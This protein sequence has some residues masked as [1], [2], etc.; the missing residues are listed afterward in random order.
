M[1]AFAGVFAWR[2]RVARE[3]D[4]STRYVL[5]NHMLFRISETLPTDVN[6]LLACCNPVP[7][8][9][10]LQAH[11]LLSIIEDAR[12]DSGL[13]PQPFIFTRYSESTSVAVRDS[14]GK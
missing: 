2:D 9:V 13:S 5:P 1:K 14:E 4:E 7:P 11:D 3:E 8:L 12:K 10:R 6:S